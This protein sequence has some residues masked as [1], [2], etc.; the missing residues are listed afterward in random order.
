MLS[1]LL[2]SHSWSYR[3]LRLVISQWCILHVPYLDPSTS[4]LFATILLAIYAINVLWMNH[5]LLSFL[6]IL[7]VRYSVFDGKLFLLFV[8]VK[9]FKLGTCSLYHNTRA[10]HHFLHLLCSLNRNSINNIVESP[11]THIGIE[12]GPLRWMYR[13]FN[14]L[15]C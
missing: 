4:F 5:F 11:F 9:W 15:S 6:F 7:E 12:A 13:S 14:C 10:F 8:L 3:T 1:K 2:G